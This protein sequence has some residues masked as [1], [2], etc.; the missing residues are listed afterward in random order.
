MAIL[1]T[2]SVQISNYVPFK[3]RAIKFALDNWP[4]EFRGM[5][6]GA[7]GKESPVVQ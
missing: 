5:D 4:S 6:A 1:H 2:T 7:K 3:M